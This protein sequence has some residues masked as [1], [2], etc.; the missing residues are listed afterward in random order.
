MF[1]TPGAE[2]KSGV[3]N[4]IDE[5]IAFNDALV[6]IEY[7]LLA[8]AIACFVLFFVTLRGGNNHASGTR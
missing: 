6:N 4:D 1:A 2:R 5:F 8:A 7:V 3:M